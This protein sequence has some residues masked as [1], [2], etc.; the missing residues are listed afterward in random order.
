MKLKSIFLASLSFLA[1]SST[2][3]ANFKLNPFFHNSFNQSKEIS[4]F[5]SKKTK[6]FIAR[7]TFYGPHEDKYGCKLACGLLAKEG[8]T[9][10][11]HS[12][13]P[14]FTK[15]SIPEFDKMLPNN[16]FLIEDRGSAI[17][18]KRASRG[19]TYVFDVFLNKRNRELNRFASKMPPYMTV[20]IL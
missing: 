4:H 18:S 10:A 3:L 16:H 15:L 19:K 2:S 13:F 8:E 14:F 17:Q 11:G 7:I 9:V 6:S 5:S 20:S 12:N 1:L